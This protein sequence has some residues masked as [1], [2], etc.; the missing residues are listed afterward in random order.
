LALATI[1]PRR[2]PARLAPAPVEPLS[3]LGSLPAFETLAPLI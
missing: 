1:P 2:P 3:P